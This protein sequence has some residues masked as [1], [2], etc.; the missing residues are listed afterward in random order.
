MVGLEEECI[1]FGINEPQS[2]SRTGFL[3]HYKTV[4]Y[5]YDK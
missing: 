5:S 3:T 4:T 2:S 1:I